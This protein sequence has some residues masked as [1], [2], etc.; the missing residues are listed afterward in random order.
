MIGLGITLQITYLKINNYSKNNIIQHLNI[1]LNAIYSCK[2]K[3]ATRII[4]LWSE[5]EKV[6]L[7]N[8]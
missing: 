1:E 2:C 7:G 8:H 4:L 5:L 6:I 3:F